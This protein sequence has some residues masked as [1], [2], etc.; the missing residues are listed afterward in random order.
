MVSLQNN[1]MFTFVE[2]SRLKLY[3]IEDKKRIKYSMKLDFTTRKYKDFLIYLKNSN[4]PV[5]TIKDWITK[6][7]KNGIILRHDV[8]RNPNQSVKI[9]EIASELNIKGT[10]NFRVLKNRLEER[11]IT[12]ISNL[13]HEIGYHYEDLSIVDGN[14][15]QA[16][17]LFNKNLGLL[18]NIVKVDTATMHGSPLSSFDN[19]DIWKHVTTSHF[20]LLGEAY[21]TIDYTNLYY[22][23]DT[24]RTWAETSANLRDNVLSS[25]RTPDFI[26]ST[27]D[28]I[29]FIVSNKNVSIAMVFH[30]ERWSSNY[31][32]FFF[33]AISDFIISQIKRILRIL[34]RF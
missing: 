22:L 5:F 27:D 19:R 11:H 30:P 33:Q 17:E 2:N 7:P 15:D 3:D 14:I 25:K 20:N 32:H 6:Q 29:N 16:I 18:R 34:R 31:F 10:F 28:I 24:G 21:I 9:A 12:K 8:D 23:T 13:G 4:I 1:C 26:K